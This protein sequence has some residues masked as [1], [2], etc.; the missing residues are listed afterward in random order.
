[1]ANAIGPT[2]PE[3][4]KA[5]GLLGLPFSWNCETG[6]LTYDERL[7]AYKVAAINGVLQAHDPA[8]EPAVTAS[9]SDGQLASVLLAK[10]LITQADVD[11]ALASNAAI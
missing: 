6:E 7:S 2:F 10:R 8:R 11:A 9:I 4:L 1:M 3:E 5:A